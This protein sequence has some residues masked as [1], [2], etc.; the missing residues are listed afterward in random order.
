M[1]LLYAGGV[2]PHCYQNRR[3]CELVLGAESCLLRTPEEKIPLL[4][5]LYL[6]VESLSITTQGCVLEQAFPPRG[7]LCRGWQCRREGGQNTGELQ[8]GGWTRWPTEVPSNPYY[9][10]IFCD[11]LWPGTGGPAVRSGWQTCWWM[12]G[13]CSSVWESDARRGDF[14]VGKVRAWDE[15][16]GE[17]SLEQSWE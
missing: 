6:F 16:Y 12:A 17:F 15:R 4:K 1:L 9:S 2:L 7:G 14:G 5:P 10:V 11:I 3:F 8:L 13:L